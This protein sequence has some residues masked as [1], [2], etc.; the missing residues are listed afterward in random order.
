MFFGSASE[1]FAAYV[2][3]MLSNSTRHEASYDQ[4]AEVTGELQRIPMVR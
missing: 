2:F 4:A 3:F 1:F